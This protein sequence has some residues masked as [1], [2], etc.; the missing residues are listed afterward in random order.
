MMTEQFP[1]GISKTINSSVVKLEGTLSLM[2]E[3]LTLDPPFSSFTRLPLH[4]R[5]YLTNT[6]MFDAP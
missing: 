3:A 5:G 1:L 4:E 6:E 2:T